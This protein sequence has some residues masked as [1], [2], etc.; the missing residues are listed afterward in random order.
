MDEVCNTNIE[1]IYMNLLLL[2]IKDQLDYIHGIALYIVD[3]GTAY[4][5]YI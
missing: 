2:L 1:K 5:L 4:L 3:F